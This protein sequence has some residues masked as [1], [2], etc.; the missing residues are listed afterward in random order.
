MKLHKITSF[1]SIVLD[2]VFAPI[3]PEGMIK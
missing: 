3:L 1:I 2:Q